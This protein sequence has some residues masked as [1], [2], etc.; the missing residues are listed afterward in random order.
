ME[1]D[2]SGQCFRI[3]GIVI[4]YFIVAIFDLSHD[5]DVEAE[6]RLS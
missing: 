4:F 1:V 3:Y 2:Y 5:H 6:F